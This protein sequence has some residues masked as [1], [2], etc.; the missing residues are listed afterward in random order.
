MIGGYFLFFFLLFLVCLIIFFIFLRHPLLPWLF[1]P[2]VW[3]Y[4]I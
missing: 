3:T 1:T 2:V 4:Y